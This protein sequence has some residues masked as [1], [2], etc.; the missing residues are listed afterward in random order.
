M[1]KGS[2]FYATLVI[3][4]ILFSSTVK[5]QSIESKNLVYVLATDLTMDKYVVLYKSLQ[6]DDSFSIEKDCVPAHVI[7][8][9]SKGLI[10]NEQSYEQLKKILNDAD[11]NVV[12]HLK[13]YDNDRFMQKCL[14]AR[15]GE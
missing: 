13:D 3:A 2:T 10:G 12:S 11:I 1:K 7:C 4:S 5:A 8:F 15:R 9:N 6:S 14:S